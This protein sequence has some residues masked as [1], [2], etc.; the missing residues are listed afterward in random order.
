MYT[1]EKII[2][3]IRTCMHIFI[4]IFYYFSCCYDYLF[5]R[6]LVFFVFYAFR[7]VIVEK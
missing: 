2:A 1:H 3:C 4:F 5:V 7:I 6:A